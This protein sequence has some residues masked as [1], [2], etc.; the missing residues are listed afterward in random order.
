[1]SSW[2]P[3]P[4]GACLSFSAFATGFALMLKRAL[5]VLEC[6]QELGDRYEGSRRLVNLLV[7]VKTM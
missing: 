5:H 4:S 1:M 2:P 3:Y 6:Q 7:A